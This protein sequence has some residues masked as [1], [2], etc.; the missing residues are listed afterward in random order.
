M[1]AIPPR[2]CPACGVTRHWVR[3]ADGHLLCV[4]CCYRLEV[5]AASQPR[6]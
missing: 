2:Y 1:S 6:T 5:V 3:G 4:V